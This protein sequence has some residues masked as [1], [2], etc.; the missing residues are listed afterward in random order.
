MTREI[1]QMRGHVILCGWGRVGK[2]LAG[3]L[4]AAGEQIVVVDRDPA[5]LADLDLP[6]VEGDVTDDAVL[7][8]AGIERARVLV[9]ALATDADNVFVTLSAR[10]LRPDLLVLARARTDDTERNLRRA[11]A[12]RVVNAQRLG[13][14]RLAAFA[15][16]PHVADF[17]DVVMHDRNLEFRLEEVTVDER[18]PLAT[19]RLADARIAETTGALLLALRDPHGAFL[20]QPGPDTVLLP[21]TVL[22]VIGTESQVAHLRR[23]FAPRA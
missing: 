14:E 1:G 17:L 13:G 8:A 20:L 21:G 16:Q 7:H 12:N 10:T 19:A 6:H 5:R 23:F 11:G 3:H 18:S 22:I 9:A 2:A 4:R 15:R